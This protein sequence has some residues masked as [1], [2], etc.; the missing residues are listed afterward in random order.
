MSLFFYLLILFIYL[1]I[2][3]F[4]LVH[5]LYYTFQSQ[6]MAVASGHIFDQTLPYDHSYVC[7]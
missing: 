7:R 5:S 4:T 6:T 3:L 1:F 2:L